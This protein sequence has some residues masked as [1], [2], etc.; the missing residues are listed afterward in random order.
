M[1][2]LKKFDL[3]ILEKYKSILA[4]DEVGRGCIAGPL[5]VAGVILK[6]DFFDERIND[7]K[8]I[9]SISF[10]KE[11]SNLIKNNCL[12]YEIEVFDSDFVD[13]MNPKQTSRYGMKKISEKLINLYDICITDYEKI[14]NPNL[15]QLNLT[16]GD[17]KSFSIACASIIA[18][19]KRDEIMNELNIK[20]PNYDFLNNQGYGT[21][22]HIEILKKYGAL[23]KVHRFSY[24]IIKNL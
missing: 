17:Q 5:V 4:M 13:K 2:E 10:R 23:R 6:N 24:K 1:N 15:N 11:L 22:K 9:K 14:D 20:Y 21:K 3:K 18:K 8:K 19:S 12:H 16:K 7:S